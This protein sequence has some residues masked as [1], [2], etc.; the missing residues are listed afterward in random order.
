MNVGQTVLPAL[1]AEGEPLV[2]DPQTVQ[3]R[4]LQVVNV[5]WIFDDVEAEV[6]GSTVLE[7]RLDAPADETV[8]LTGIP[9]PGPLDL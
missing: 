2:V 5:N 4:R 1:K 8:D 9:E 3:D 7:A 6:V